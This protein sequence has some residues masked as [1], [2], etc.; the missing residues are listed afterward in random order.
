MK[1]IYILVFFISINIQAKT[2][3]GIVTDD[4]GLPLPAV[5]IIVEGS[6]NGV[7]T[8]IDGKYSIEAEEG[9]I[10]V[11]SFI[12]LKMKKLTVGNKTVLNVVLENDNSSLDEVIVSGYS[13]QIKI[14]GVSSFRE[15][16]TANESYKEIEE[17]KFKL[18]KTSPL[19][20]FSIDVDKAGYSNIRRMINTGSEIPKDAVKIEEMVN[21]F[22][23]D[24]K[25]PKGN[26]PFSIQTELIQTPWNSDTKLVKIG[27]KGKEIPLDNVPPSNLVFL[28][29]VS[30]SMGQ[31]NKLPL[32]KSAFSLLTNQLREQDKISIVVY[33]GAAGIVLEPTSGNQK[34]KIKEALNKLNAGG[35]TAGGQGIELAYQIARDNFI[36]NGNNRVI[37]ATDGDFNVGLQS[38][39]AMK[40]LIIEQRESG[41][42]LTAL[43]FGMG[44][45]KDSKLETLA[46]AGN[47]NHAYIDSMQE[48]QRVLG[49]E[50]G[51]TMYTIA[52][53]VKIQVEFNPENVEAFR[54]I[55]YENRLL[56]DEDFKDDKKD[57]GELGSGHNVTAIYEIIPHGSKSDYLKVVDDYKYSQQVSKGKNSEELLTVKFRYKEPTGKKSK[58]I[59]SIVNTSSEKAPSEDFNFISAVAL[60]GMNLRESEFTNGKNLAMV[61]KLAENGRGKDSEGYRAEF[62]RLVKS[63]ESMNENLAEDN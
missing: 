7:Q 63:Y 3:T 9:D 39:S 37:L 20:T 34:N 35:S 18:V 12:G 51:G 59:E 17:N 50:F 10:L 48:A 56:N 54:L 49:T 36:K 53:D 13:K 58:V 14:R 26:D 16:I 41:V 28:L 44:N 23:Y 33:A 40:D 22:N 31:P 45:Y 2:I 15:H 21:Y 60:F 46:Q 42:F 8:D 19:S 47:G 5:N 11:F 30:G 27:I 29:D 52:K 1:L 55:G 4:Q 32:L 57:A 38:D 25:Q 43:G 6:A 62:I 24:Y 61:L